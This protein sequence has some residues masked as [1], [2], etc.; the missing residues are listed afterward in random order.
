MLKCSNMQHKKL[1]ICLVVTKGNWGGAQRYV[2]DLATNLPEDSYDVVVITGQGNILKNKLKERDIKTYELLNLKRDISII[3]EIKIFFSLLKIIW[4]EKPDVLHLNSPKVSGL[5]AVAGKLCGTKKIIQTIHG[6][7]FNE[8]RAA[9]TTNL[10]G[11]FSWITVLLCHKTIIIAEKEKLQILSIP[12]IN[13][14]KIV[15]I[16]NGIEKIEFKKKYMAKKELLT[17]LSKTVFDN[18][19]HIIDIT[20]I[21]TIAELHK[22]KGLEYTIRAMAEIRKPFVFFIIGEG[23]ERERLEKIIK[24]KNL[25]DRVFLVG[26]MDKANQYL[27]AFDIFTL[28]S[29]KEGLP[30]SI[31]EAGLAGLPVVASS[32]GGIPDI[33]E[34]GVSGMLVNKVAPPEI[35][36]A[37]DYLI[38]TKDQRKIFGEKLKEKVEKEFS[39]EEM[40]KKTLK[41]YNL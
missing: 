26:F 36:Q 17:T 8:N 32:V 40:I 38:N 9:I 41:L 16:K 12:F 7:S 5:G 28:T 23:E 25:E 14:T 6:W 21:G 22:N 35:T 18:V 30:Y 39:V 19:S 33:I 20:W 4:K 13:K 2:Y 10:I 3:S 1:K 15:L 31:L 27:K 11:F 29:I 34:N 37:I 24:E